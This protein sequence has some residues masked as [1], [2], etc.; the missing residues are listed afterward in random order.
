MKILSDRVSGL[1]CLVVKKKRSKVWG[2]V[3]LA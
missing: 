1:L 3:I 2:F